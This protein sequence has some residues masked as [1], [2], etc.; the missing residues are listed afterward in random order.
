MERYEFISPVEDRIVELSNNRFRK[1]I[2]RRGSFR[3]PQIGKQSD[4]DLVVDDKFL[5]ATIRNFNN[6]AVDDVHYIKNHNE[7]DVSDVYGTVIALEKTEEGLDGIFE[8][9]DDE[10]RRKLLN[11]SLP[12][13]VSAGLSFSPSNPRSRAATARTGS[14]GPCSGTWPRRSF[15]G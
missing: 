1:Q 5:D 12:R 4:H 7:E 14:T 10:V 13:G 11:K 6:G 8:I 15:R 3:H 2:L 9:P